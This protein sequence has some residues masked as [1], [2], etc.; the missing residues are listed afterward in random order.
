DI[1]TGAVLDLELCGRRVVVERDRIAVDGVSQPTHTPVR[2]I[3]ILL[4]VASVEV[5]A[6]D[7]EASLTA[8]ALGGPAEIRVTARH[9]PVMFRSARVAEL[10]SIWTH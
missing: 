2:R 5:F 6:N 9:A 8:Y 7:G 10:D 4:D 1:R 3:D